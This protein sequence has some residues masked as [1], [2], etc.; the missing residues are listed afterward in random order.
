[1][2]GKPVWL[3]DEVQ[4]EIES[5]EFEGSINQILEKYFVEGNPLTVERVDELEE[6]LDRLEELANG[7]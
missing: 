1:M 2:S 3:S 7:R 5:L 4:E 6:R